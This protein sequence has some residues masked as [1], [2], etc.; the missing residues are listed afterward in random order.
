M[1]IDIGVEDV[2][3]GILQRVTP[4]VIAQLHSLTMDNE[5]VQHVPHAK[6]NRS[7]FIRTRQH[8]ETKQNRKASDNER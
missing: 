8:K 3:G 7:H 1:G 2:D 4:M 5:H 6:H